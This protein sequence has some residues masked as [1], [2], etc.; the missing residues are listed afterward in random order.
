MASKQLG[1]AACI[2]IENRSSD[3]LK[4]AQRSAKREAMPDANLTAFAEAGTKGF[5]DGSSVFRAKTIGD[6]RPDDAVRRNAKDSSQSRVYGLVQEC[7]SA[8]YA[9]GK[10]VIGSNRPISLL[11][12][13]FGANC[14]TLL[15]I[16]PNGW[17]SP[18]EML[19][20]DTFSLCS[21]V[22][23]IAIPSDE[24]GLSSI[25]VNL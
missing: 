18:G 13:L 19:P 6:G 4:I 5:A 11:V 17:S 22:R 7:S 16:G 21:G 10:E 12:A 1:D 9:H 8:Q 25:R 2:W 3:R 24:S 23:N 15:E 14:G 20:Q